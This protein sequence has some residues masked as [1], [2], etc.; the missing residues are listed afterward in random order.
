MVDLEHVVR[1]STELKVLETESG[2]DEHEDGHFGFQGEH[3]S[4]EIVPCDG[5][6]ELSDLLRAE[7]EDLEERQEGLDAERMISTEP[8]VCTKGLADRLRDRWCQAVVVGMPLCTRDI[9]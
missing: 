9:D 4:R 3:V 1:L 2:L 7:G 6:L 8:H 5:L